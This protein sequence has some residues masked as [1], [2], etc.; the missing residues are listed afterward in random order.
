[1]RKVLL[2]VLAGI[3]STSLWAQNDTA[4]R[5]T[6]KPGTAVKGGD[7]FL[8]QLGGFSWSNRP[9]SIKTKGLSRTF[10]MYF[11]FDFPFKTNPKFSVAIGPGIATDHIFFD[12][13]NVGIAANTP[14][15][16]FDNVSDTNHFKKY[17]LTTAFAEVP[18]EL[19]FTAD[20]YNHNRSVKIALGAK[21]G[22]LL[23]AVVKG[24]ELQNSADRTVNNYTM[25]EKS[26]RFFNTTRLSL[27]G[28]VGYGPFS[29]FASYGI[30]P[31]FKEGLGP[32]VRPLSV[33]LTISGL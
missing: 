20:P 28:R 16:V 7:H 17:K 5:K 14:A 32:Q 29:L 4:A 23:T 31:V 26:K 24:K 10:N 18:V 27:S 21:V 22:T 25:K 1:M 9:D 3:L 33:G 11:L 30:T 8:I 15:V 12:E 19:R 13:T 6:V 2:V